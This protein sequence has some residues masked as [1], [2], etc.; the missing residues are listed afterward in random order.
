MNFS[1]IDLIAAFPFETGN[2]VLVDV[3]AHHGFSS[4]PFAE[5]GWR[6]IAFEPEPANLAAF[7]SNMAQYPNV[8]CLPLAVSDKQAEEVPFF[9]SSEHYGI[10]S[11]KPFHETHQAS[12]K[13]RTVRLDNVLEGLEIGKVT[14]LKIDVEGADFPA[15]KGFSVERY[16][17]DIVM[18]EFMDARTRSG[19]D[20]DHHDV[21]EY[22]ARRGYSAFV[23]EWSPVTEYAREGVPSQAHEWLEC[24]QYPL[25]HQPNWGNLIF[26]P[27]D[28][29]NLLEATLNKYL[30]GLNRPVLDWLRFHARRVPGLKTAYRF[31]KGN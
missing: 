16:K 18:L 13:V 23:S 15:L 19:F 24:T 27:H 3:G 14:V 7:E 30:R 31:I 2:P 29:L 20:Y 5:R 22:M 17:P 11:L 8:S 1:E 4:L 21:V 9:I 10:H 12:L 28:K 25:G 26:V 6:V